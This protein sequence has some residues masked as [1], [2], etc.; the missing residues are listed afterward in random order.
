[1]PV[2]EPTNMLLLG[3]LN[4]GR[5]QRGNYKWNQVEKWIGEVVRAEDIMPLQYWHRIIGVVEIEEAAM[6]NK[7]LNYLQQFSIIFIYGGV[8]KGLVLEK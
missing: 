1:M 3:L 6:T 4:L 2:P 8:R 7:K 5:G